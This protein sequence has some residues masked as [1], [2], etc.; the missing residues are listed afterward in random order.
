MRKFDPWPVFFKREWKRNWPFLVGFAVTGALITKL[1][2]GL[3][4][5]EAKNSKFVKAHKR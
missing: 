4:E 3:T 1:S 5:E 2:L